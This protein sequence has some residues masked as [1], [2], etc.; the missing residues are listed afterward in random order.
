MNRKTS[1]ISI[2]AA[3]AI[4]LCIRNC[5][6]NR[7]DRTSVPYQHLTGTVFHTIYHI[8]YADTADYHQEIRQLFQEFDASLSMFNKNSL[9]SRINRNDTTAI[10][11]AYFSNL[12]A[13]ARYVSRLT[14]GAFDITVA[15]LVN[16][17]GFGYTRD[18]TTVTPQ[19]VDSCRALVGFDKVELLPDGRVIK[20][21]PNMILDA[22]SI[23]KGYMCD[24]IAEWLRAKGVS[25]YMIEIGGE[26]NL[27]GVN[28]RGK[29]WTI[30]INRPE[31]DSTNMQNEIQEVVRYS[32]GVATSGNYRN[33]RTQGDTRYSHTID[34]HS[35][36]PIQQDILSS[37]V[38]AADCMTADAFATAFMVMGSEKAQQVL[39]KDTTIMAYFILTPAENS[40]EYRIVCSPKL[41]ELIDAND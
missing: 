20:A 23:A 11:D 4:V 15:P 25:N 28:S 12:F 5:N 8:Q 24:V 3:I 21:H 34:P 37:T 36:Y 29:K 30:G 38:F 32:G 39:D 14:G 9:I 2:I 40:T 26:I 35:G 7:P 31:I 13:K 18:T 41:K 17:W 33:F 6:S 27:S 19:M 16:L 10:A 22:S 1:I